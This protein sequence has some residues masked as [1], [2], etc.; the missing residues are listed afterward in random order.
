MI[1]ILDKL[2]HTLLSIT[3]RRVIVT[4]K[5]FDFWFIISLN[6]IIKDYDE[7]LPEGAG[8]SDLVC[9]DMDGNYVVIEFKAGKDSYDALDRLISYKSAIKKRWRGGWEKF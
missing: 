7:V 4:H 6:Q 3:L 8:I 9:V 2:R 1:I 5:N